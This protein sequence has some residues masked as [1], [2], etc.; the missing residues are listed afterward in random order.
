M[1]NTNYL[2]LKAWAKRGFNA[3]TIKKNCRLVREDAVVG[4]LYGI[5]LSETYEYENNTTRQ[6]EKTI[7]TDKGNVVVAGVPCKPKA[8]TDSEKA[9]EKES[10]ENMRVAKACTR[11]ITSLSPSR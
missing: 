5:R 8:K 3:K 7:A 11:A 1:D 10:K 4:K 6:G 9:C 2:P